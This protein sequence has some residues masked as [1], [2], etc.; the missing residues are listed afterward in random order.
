MFNVRSHWKKNMLYSHSSRIHL[1][2]ALASSHQIKSCLCQPNTSMQLNAIILRQHSSILLNL[3]IFINQP[4]LHVQLQRR[5]YLGNRKSWCWFLLKYLWY[6]YIQFQLQLEPSLMME[7]KKQVLILYI[8]ILF[9]PS[10][11]K[12]VKKIQYDDCR[13]QVVRSWLSIND[14]WVVMGFIEI[15]ESWINSGRKFMSSGWIL[16]LVPFW[17][18]IVLGEKRIVLGV[19][20]AKS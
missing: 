11:K 17:Y 10:L 6:L 8:L 4:A 12:N 18:A 13:N 2:H 7:T 20:L 16:F 1:L 5:T 15:H 19:E 9:Q 14:S 3:L